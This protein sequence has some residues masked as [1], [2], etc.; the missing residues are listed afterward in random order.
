[1][2]ITWNTLFKWSKKEKGSIVRYGSLIHK[3]HLI[4][5]SLRKEKFFFKRTKF[6]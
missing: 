3:N 1:M 4:E 6:R 5:P 2:K